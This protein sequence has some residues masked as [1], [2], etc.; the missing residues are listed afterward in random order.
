MPRELPHYKDVIR[1]IQTE[2][3]EEAKAESEGIV[4]VERRP[5]MIEF[6]KG[7]GG[8]HKMSLHMDA[9]GY[10]TP[11]YD[12]R[13]RQSVRSD[14]YNALWHE[15]RSEIFRT[16]AR[17][18]DQNLP[19]T[20]NNAYPMDERKAID[21]AMEQTARAVRA[22][23][24]YGYIQNP[25]GLFHSYLGDFLGRERVAA[26]LRIAGNHATLQTFNAV[27]EHREK[28]E[29][30]HA[31]EPNALVYWMQNSEQQGSLEVD[32][33]TVTTSKV[34][35]FALH[36]M[37][38]TQKWE[39]FRKLST[40][41][42][43]E[44][45]NDIH[46]MVTLVKKALDLGVTL[47]YTTA[48][49]Y[50]RNSFYIGNQDLEQR[51][52]DETLALSDVYA[53][54]RGRRQ[55]D[56][57]AEAMQVVAATSMH[58]LDI[59]ELLD[60]DDYGDLERW[61]RYVQVCKEAR[62]KRWPKFSRH[63]KVRKK[64][65]RKPNPDEILQFLNGE[66]LN[67]FTS[68]IS[69]L[70]LL[71]IGE[72]SIVAESLSGNRIS[73]H[74]DQ[75]GKLE[76]FPLSLTQSTVPSGHNGV[77]PAGW[78]VM[79]FGTEAL[80]NVLK[81]VVDEY[82]DENVADSTLRKPNQDLLLKNAHHI[83]NAYPEI[84]GQFEDRALAAKI[85]SAVS[86]LVRS[87][88][89]DLAHSVLNKHR[90]DDNIHTISVQQY[91]KVASGANAFK[92]L[93][94]TNWIAAYWY[95]RDDG[96]DSPDESVN[97]PGQVITLVR[98]RLSSL[99]FDLR[100]WRKLTYVSPEMVHKVLDAKKLVNT[101][102]YILNILA[103][104]QVEPDPIFFVRTPDS[105]GWNADFFGPEQSDDIW[106][107]NEDASFTATE[108]RVY[109]LVLKES[110]RIRGENSDQLPQL[111]LMAQYNDAVD[112]AV[113]MSYY[114]QPLHSTTW[115]GVVRQC[116]QWHR[117]R[118]ANSYAHYWQKIL[119]EN[120]GHYNGWN[121]LVSEQEIDGYT[122]IP[123]TDEKSLYEES[124]EMSHCVATYGPKCLSGYTRLF[125]IYQEDEHIATAE[126]QYYGSRWSS[127]Q[128][129]GKHNHPVDQNIYRAVDELAKI[130]NK[131][132]NSTPEEERHA[133]WKIRDGQ[134]G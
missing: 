110:G 28:L 18:M 27:L 25:S 82:W 56:L 96:L 22:T 128:V 36:Q 7:L 125:G 120:N 115:N 39:A 67:K 19:F 42:I 15:I 17:I 118:N 73:V 75:N 113:D 69:D 85:V 104:E 71:Q 122:A 79:G 111:Q 65:V 57:V 38:S 99:G 126:V 129:R 92:S 123:L 40:R 24:G 20:S 31:S 1:F 77:M 100:N 130:Y 12:F 105:F 74:S 78:S 14:W 121:S 97:H 8:A 95:L 68:Y 108:D 33:D 98:N 16:I 131:E 9:V 60:S 3:Y 124:L 58:K 112:M 84:C 90:S 5:G 47:R 87:D 59:S 93:S 86:R 11:F 119:R 117:A 81:E 132:W 88:I 103:S 133:S 52:R 62:V 94:Q 41:L 109:R 83:R 101:K 53:R 76:V 116:E 91:N 46:T 63:R 66:A 23:L 54:K 45:P 43:R 49:A 102:A 114:N 107:E 32:L 127:A 64:S 70:Q 2:C 13:I 10:V 30:I 34:K 26:T 21:R 89:M 29:E 35:A 134:S 106:T 80:T 44:H 55:V 72:K 51:L 48:K 37:D 61:D 4:P 6:G 50:I